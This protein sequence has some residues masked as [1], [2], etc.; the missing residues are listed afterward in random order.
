MVDTREYPK[1]LAERT[2]WFTETFCKPVPVPGS[3]DTALEEI[4]DAQGHDQLLQTCTE[5]VKEK[6]WVPRISEEGIK[7]LWQEMV[8]GIEEIH[9]ERG[10]PWVLNRLTKLPREIISKIRLN[11]GG[12][13]WHTSFQGPKGTGKSSLYVLVL[14]HALFGTWPANTGNEDLNRESA[15]H[16][17]SRG[18]EQGIV[19]YAYVSVS[20]FAPFF[21][22]LRMHMCLIRTVCL[23]LLK[24]SEA[25]IQSEPLRSSSRARQTRRKGCARRSRKHWLE[26][27]RSK[28]PAGCWCCTWTRWM[29]CSLVRARQ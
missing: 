24:Q 3:L 7:R 29:A 28:R 5:L 4:F 25:L 20:L 23:L 1:E 11:D 27:A 13:N 10:N 8:R 16:A 9:D 17:K 18:G 2:C 22:C 12:M 6:F 19:P 21:Y 14:L 26:S 15:E